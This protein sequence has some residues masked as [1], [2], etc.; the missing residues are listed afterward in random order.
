MPQGSK[1]CTCQ[2]HLLMRE[3][4]H[5]V[6]SNLGEIN[7]REGRDGTSSFRW[8]QLPAS[9]I[10]APW[11]PTGSICGWRLNHSALSALRR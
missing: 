8:H 5:I 7:A 9:G 1:I 3:T 4:P 11:K 2:I 6:A 10:P